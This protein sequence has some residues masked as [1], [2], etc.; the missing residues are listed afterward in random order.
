MVLLIKTD[1]LRR[2]A[3]D[4]AFGAAEAVRGCT[5]LLGLGAQRLRA[6]LQAR[7][8]IRD[9]EAELDLQVQVVGELTYA[10][11]RGEPTDQK[12]VEETMEFMD[13]LRQELAGCQQKLD[14]LRGAV[15]CAACGASNDS[16]NLYCG[17]CGKPLGRQ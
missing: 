9:L 14:M 12:V 17:W 1:K 6:R 3:Q 15:V 8:E 5:E 7:R 16:R 2:C 11:H 10:A 13:S 4:A